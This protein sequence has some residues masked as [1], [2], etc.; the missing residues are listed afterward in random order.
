MSSL[1][2]LV[3]LSL[4]LLALAVAGFLWAVDRRQFDDLDTPAWRILLDD[5][6]APPARRDADDAAARADRPDDGRG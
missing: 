6:R 4:L 5:D 3:P 2:I 1:A